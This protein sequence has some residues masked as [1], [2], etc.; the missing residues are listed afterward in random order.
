MPPPTNS[1]INTDTKKSH[2]KIYFCS[3]KCVATYQTNWFTP[4][5]AENFFLCKFFSFLIDVI[6]GVSVTVSVVHGPSC[7]CLFLY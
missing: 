1:N 6:S 5:N 7:S 2:V 3:H 4:R